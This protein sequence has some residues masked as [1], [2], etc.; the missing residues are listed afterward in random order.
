[1]E[2]VVVD[3]IVGL[4]APTLLE[5]GGLQYSSKSLHLI[6]PP[7]VSDIEVNTLQGLV[8]LLDAKVE[9]VSYSDHF[10]HVV[11]HGTV[12]VI[13]RE[14]NDH[15]QRQVLIEATVL[16]GDR[17]YQFNQFISQEDAMIGLQACFTDAGDRDNVLKT[18]SSLTT[19]DQLQIEDNGIS[20]SATAK[21]G[22]ALVATVDIKPRVTLSPYRTFR[23]VEQPASEFVLR[24]KKGS[25]GLPLVGLFEAD[26]GAWK[27][28]AIHNVR[29]WLKSQK[30]VFTIVA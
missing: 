20:Q 22:V 25:N 21:S 7:V 29:D 1:M 18:I 30:P 11:D 28:D 9:G 2:A 23:E 4:T 13:G 19:N 14:S 3:K 12:K 27:M 24:I 6:T 16:G 10:I 8:D 5:I 26:G 15:A 17:S